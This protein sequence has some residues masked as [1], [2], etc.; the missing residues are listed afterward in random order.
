M[1]N[2]QNHNKDIKSEKVERELFSIDKSF[3]CGKLQPSDQTRVN[4]NLKSSSEYMYSNIYE[5]LK[6]HDSASLVSTSSDIS[7]WSACDVLITRNE[8]AKCASFVKERSLSTISFSKKN[9]RWKERSKR[10]FSDSTLNVNYRKAPNFTFN[11]KQFAKHSVVDN[12][13]FHHIQDI[14]KHIHEY[15]QAV[16]LQRL[17]EHNRNDIC[18]QGNRL[19][20]TTRQL[21]LT[22]N[23]LQPKVIDNKELSATTLELF[24]T[25]LRNNSSSQREMNNSSSQQEMNMQSYFNVH[26]PNFSSFSF[27]V[28][29]IYE[30]RF[31]SLHHE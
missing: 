27:K 18:R 3:D 10:P 4:D 5:I 1:A 19:E 29:F 23:A 2:L 9:F 11:S 8:G 17:E 16:T 6:P 25:D 26:L 14:S 22:H 24:N 20:M 7:P 13:K 12:Y 28:S 30:K 31:S 15:K 21:W